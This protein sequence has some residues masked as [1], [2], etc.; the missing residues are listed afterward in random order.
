MH[1]LPPPMKKTQQYY[2][3]RENLWNHTYFTCAKVAKFYQK[4]LAKYYETH[5]TEDQLREM[6]ENERL[7]QRDQRAQV[8]R[9]LDSNRLHRRKFERT[10]VLPTQLQS[11]SKQ[12]L[13]TLSQPV[14]LH[15][16][17]DS[18]VVRT[19]KPAPVSQVE[20]S[21]WADIDF[22]PVQQIKK[23]L[24]RKELMLDDSR[25]YVGATAQL[26]AK[27]AQFEADQAAQAQKQQEL[28]DQHRA[29][30]ARRHQATADLERKCGIFKYRANPLAS[31]MSSLSSGGRFGL[32]KSN[33]T[34]PR[35]QALSQ[36]RD[37]Y[38]PHDPLLYA[39]F[40]G[41][42]QAQHRNAVRRMRTELS[43]TTSISQ[44]SAPSLV[45]GSQQ[46]RVS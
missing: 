30:L 31:T 46:T 29:E 42:I 39:E 45:L 38:Q 18:T 34:S 16:S 2:S 5:P 26:L 43:R 4:P 25:T 24:P 37:P 9:L 44:L 17:I 28:R 11:R 1:S 20:I 21:A 12:V 7:E 14:S 33:T 8:S 19:L 22:L 32:T 6:Q 40:R 27:R 23:F 41:L 35:S 13:T 36:A 10:I 3:F 15:S